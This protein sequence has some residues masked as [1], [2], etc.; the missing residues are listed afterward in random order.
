MRERLEN[1]TLKQKIIIIVCMLTI[2]VAIF[3]MIYRTYYGNDGRLI[4]EN[5]ISNENY[6]ERNMSE[7]IRGK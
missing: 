7:E 4:I 3:I 1:L 2:M 6:E 5:E